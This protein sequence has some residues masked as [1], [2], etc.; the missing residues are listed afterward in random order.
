MAWGTVYLLC[1][2][3]YWDTN[4][5]YISISGFNRNG[6]VDT[7]RKLPDTAKNLTCLT[8]GKGGYQKGPEKIN[9]IHII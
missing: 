4:S 3:G 1:P 5:I 2:S 8:I 9:A 7:H 6:M